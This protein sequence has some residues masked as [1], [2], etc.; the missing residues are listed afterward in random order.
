[1]KILL[2]TSYFLSAYNIKRFSLQAD[3]LIEIKKRQHDYYYSDFVYFECNAK[4]SKFDCTNLNI[5]TQ[6]II[7]DPD[8][9]EIPSK[10]QPIWELACF[11]R[12]YHTDYI[13][14]IHYATAIVKKMDFFL[15]EEKEFRQL[16]STI[17][18]ELKT[19]IGSKYQII[20]F[21]NYAEYIKKFSFS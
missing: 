12:K 9:N 4:A 5:I 19:Q 15:S 3:E 11:L 8:F 13:D 7:N 10:S 17:E 16:I 18:S 21:L 14:C 1:M 6:A 20:P 2:D